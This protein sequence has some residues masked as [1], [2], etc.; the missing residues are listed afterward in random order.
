[1]LARLADGNVYQEQCATIEAQPKLIK[2][3]ELK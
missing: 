2:M 3:T 1:M